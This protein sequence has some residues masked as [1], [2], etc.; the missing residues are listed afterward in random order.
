MKCGHSVCIGCVQRCV[1]KK[2]SKAVVCPPCNE[3]RNPLDESVT[4]RTVVFWMLSDIAWE[5]TKD[6][7]LTADDKK[8]APGK[9]L[10]VY[11]RYT[12]VEFRA[13]GCQPVAA[14]LCILEETRRV[15]GCRTASGPG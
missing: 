11:P 3:K 7:K 2:G 13:S 6:E 8:H 15:S 9:V 4:T 14:A 1:L 12:M 5:K 10:D